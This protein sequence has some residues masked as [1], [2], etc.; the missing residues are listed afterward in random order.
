M[1][2]FWLT[3]HLVWECKK[4]HIRK[5]NEHVCPDSLSQQKWSY[6]TLHWKHSVVPVGVLTYLHEALRM[7][8]VAF[9]D[10]AVTAVLLVGS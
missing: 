9:V 3:I 1:S 10:V 7:S 2:T 6:Q 5:S 4:W 8:R